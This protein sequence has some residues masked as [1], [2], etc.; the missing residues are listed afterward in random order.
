VS[1]GPSSA[2][3]RKPPTPGHVVVEKVDRVPVLRHAWRNLPHLQAHAGAA[4]S[5]RLT[6]KV[7]DDRSIAGDLRV[8]YR[9]RHG[10]PLTDLCRIA[11]SWYGGTPGGSS[12][13]P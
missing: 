7:D 12:T 5:V 11:N 8:D 6:V 1:R 9:G 4:R 10:L 13:N 3:I 2:K